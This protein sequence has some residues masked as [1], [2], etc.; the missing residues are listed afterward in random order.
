MTEEQKIGC[1]EAEA[2]GIDEAWGTKIKAEND[3]WFQNGKRTYDE[4]QLIMLDKT[5]QIKPFKML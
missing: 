4:Y 2:E 1:T 3:A 5:S